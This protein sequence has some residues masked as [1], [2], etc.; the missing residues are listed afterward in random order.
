MMLRHSILTSWHGVVTG[1]NSMSASCASA[2]VF[3]EDRM[4]DNLLADMDSLCY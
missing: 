3:V 2:G 4:F 1:S